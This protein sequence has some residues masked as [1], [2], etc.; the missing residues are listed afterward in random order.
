MAELVV[1]RRYT[2]ALFQ[3]ARNASQV[4]AVQAD[5]EAVAGAMRD[6]PALLRALRAPTVST[7]KKRAIVDGAFAG[8]ISPLTLKF[9]QLLIDR[10]REAILPDVPDDFLRLANEWRNLLPAHVR[11]AAPLSDEEQ[12][13]L[14]EVL[15]RK[16]GM[17]VTLQ[18][19]VDPSLIGGLYVRMGDTVID[20]T[21][22]T[23]L[24]QVKARLLAGRLF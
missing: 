15:S 13:E 24:A 21:L 11:A 23:R 14:V 10:R 4:D 20:G 6:V 22:K 19:E 18:V 8:Q 9:I 1:V 2:K 5:L 7:E 16:T 17:N 3:A 12:A